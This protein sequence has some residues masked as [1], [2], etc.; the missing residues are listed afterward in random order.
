MTKD[1]QLL[2][3]KMLENPEFISKLILSGLYL[4]GATNPY[5]LEE[6]QVINYK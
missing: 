4:V 2:C 6:K 1:K 5:F 3:I